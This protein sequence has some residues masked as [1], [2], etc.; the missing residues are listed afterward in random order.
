MP[1]LPESELKVQTIYKKAGHPFG[2]ELHFDEDKVTPLR[3]LKSGALVVSRQS[4]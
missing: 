4:G 3:W 1:E 2:R